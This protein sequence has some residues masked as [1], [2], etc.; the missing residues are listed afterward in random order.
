M[1]MSNAEINKAIHLN[2]I[3]TVTVNLYLSCGYINILDCFLI[4]TLLLLLLVEI[5][6][7]LWT[8]KSVHVS[9]RW[10]SMSEA[11]IQ[12]LGPTLSEDKSLPLTVYVTM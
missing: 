4:L 6:T 3:S 9:C 12:C 11:S 2:K 10:K 7:S 5:H 1:F 8:L